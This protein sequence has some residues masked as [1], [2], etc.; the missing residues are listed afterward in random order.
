MPIRTWPMFELRH[1][2]HPEPWHHSIAALVGIMN[3]VSSDDPRSKTNHCRWPTLCSSGC[4]G[5]GWR[6]I[7]TEDHVGGG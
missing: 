7:A 2:H 6:A 5:I 4:S 3:C 1:L